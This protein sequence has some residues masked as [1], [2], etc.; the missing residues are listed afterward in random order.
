MKN[1]MTNSELEKMIVEE[2]LANNNL[3][4]LDSDDVQKFKKHSDFIDG[5]AVN[6]K[7]ED[8]GKLAYEALTQ[9]KEAHPHNQLTMLILKIRVAGK[10]GLATEHLDSFNV[11]FSDPQFDIPI[12]W[13]IETEASIPNKVRLCVLC[14]FKSKKI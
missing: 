4:G 5:T 8:L 10:Y 11:F 13:G 14:G 2:V 1:I 12:M 3:L 7:P 6:G 9:I